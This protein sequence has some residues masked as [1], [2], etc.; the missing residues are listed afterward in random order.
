MTP[1]PIA[2]VG[3]AGRFPESDSVDELW[4]HL[5]DGRVCATDLAPPPGADSGWIGKAYQVRDP[6][7]FDRH[8]FQMTA[9]EV[10]STDPQHRLL[11]TLA[12]E[13]LEDAAIDPGRGAVEVGVYVSSNLSRL[14]YQPGVAQPG[15][16]ATALA[17]AVGSDADHLATRIA[18]R[19]E[20]TG[21]SVTIQS[22]CSSALMAVHI[23]SQALRAGEIDLALAGGVCLR[24]PRDEGWVYDP[25]LIRSADGY[26]RPFDSASTGSVPGE[27]G[28]LVAL[29]R[30]SDAVA[31]GDY[32]YGC[33][34]ASAAGNDGA[35]RAGYLA[36]GVDGQRRVIQRALDLSR[37]DPRSIGMVEAHGSGTALGDPIEFAALSA[38]YRQAGV[39]R[40]ACALGS[41]KSNVGHLNAAAGIV[42][43]VKC[44]LA[45]DRGIIPGV[46]TFEKPSE[47]IDLEGSP[48]Y[49]PTRSAP[50]PGPE[51]GRVAALSSFGLGGANVHALIAHRD[52]IPVA[53]ATTAAEERWPLPPMFPV[54]AASPHSFHAGAEAVARAIESSDEPIETLSATLT[55]GR[56]AMALRGCT[57]GTS[58]HEV[59]STLRAIEVPTAAIKAPA[60]TYLLSGPR[61]EDQSL[62]DR[63]TRLSPGFRDFLD[64][65]APTL[66]GVDRGLTSEPEILGFVVQVGIARWL[67]THGLQPTALACGEGG[68]A[69]AFYLGGMLSLP[70]ALEFVQGRHV[71]EVEASIEIR[72]DL[73]TASQLTYDLA[74]PVDV[75]DTGVVVVCRETDAPVILGRLARQEIG[76]RLLP[77][78]TLRPRSG[79]R[80]DTRR[81]QSEVLIVR[82]ERDDDRVS[83]S[84]R[85][86][87]VVYLGDASGPAENPDDRVHRV[88]AVSTSDP[89]S[90]VGQALAAA[91]IVGAQVDLQTGGRTRSRL[92]GYVY[93]D[94]C[95]APPPVAPVVADATPTI[96]KEV[97]VDEHV[98]T[99]FEDVMGIRP[100]ADDDVFE[101]GLDSL[102]AAQI[103]SRLK[104]VGFEVRVRDLFEAESARALADLL[105]VRSQL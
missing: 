98:L 52:H 61:E 26:C 35:H 14:Y 48:F 21:P 78:L 34:L 28:A 10:R 63:M 3:L 39:D 85:V 44:L 1:D 7:S 94:E 54:S 16:E 57:I 42:G 91:W 104:D 53:V 97:P 20:L 51:H 6:E 73:Q 95:Y 5:V 76:C 72:A 101:L 47:H 13:A 36:P 84:D 87:L 45:V 62:V 81:P 31:D 9:A 77:G 103:V 80:S 58:P 75:A 60:V 79:G 23:A 56:R 22:G 29:K 64:E 41:V 89:L 90:G 88:S 93:D 19:L 74:E 68:D 96:G 4:Q 65:C 71:W 11:L 32:I 105:R 25:D 100:S 43:L 67:E 99:A 2:V 15:G 49:V 86:A 40:Q 8:L 92:P 38:T 27:G 70:E 102:L 66:N 18:Y 55:N 50:W 24:F 33:L 30:L 82:T 37:I 69:A 17:L 46:P 12:H 83:T 59:A